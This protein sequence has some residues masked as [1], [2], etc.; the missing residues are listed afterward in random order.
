M[1]P[2]P[3]TQPPTG[4]PSSHHP[5]S[6]LTFCLRRAMGPFSAE[7]HTPLP[8]SLPVPPTHG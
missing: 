2:A 7:G 3:L 1:T 5:A 4:P 8:P 6:P